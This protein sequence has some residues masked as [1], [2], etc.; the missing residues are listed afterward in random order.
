[1]TDPYATLGLTATATAADIKAAYR[2]LVKISHPDLNPDDAGAEVRFKAIASAY[3][4]LKDAA[5]RARFDAGEIDASGA[6]KPQRRYYRDFADQPGNSYQRGFEGKGDPADVFAEMLRQ[7]GKRGFPPFGE[8]GFTM[9]GQDLSFGLEV[10]FMDAALGTAKKINLPDVGPVELQIPKGAVDGMTLRLRGKGLAGPRGG[11]PGDA[12]VTLTVLP[13]PVFVREGFDIHLTLPIT[14]D[15][16]VLGAKVGVPTIDGTV[17]LTIPAGAS[18]GRTLRLRGRGV[19]NAKASAGDQLVELRIVSP[20][21][22]DDA[23]RAFMEGWRKTHPYDP[24]KTMME[25]VQE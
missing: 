2:K 19:A 20:P 7:R 10:G 17:M 22:V 1:M 15:E 4:L 9:P 16:A 11:A 13:H 21:V 3:D 12:L 18:S 23:L 24:R 25:E 14:L 5:T 8:E 6:E